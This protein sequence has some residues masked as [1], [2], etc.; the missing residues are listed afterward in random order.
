MKEIG[1]DAFHGCEFKTIYL[2]SCVSEF[3]SNWCSYTKNVEN[4]KIIPNEIKNIISYEDKFIL[5]KS[6]PKSDI[7]DV[8]LF[9]IR[10]LTEVEIPSFIKQIGKSA[11]QECE[12]LTKVTFNDDSELQ[13]IDEF[14]FADSSLESITIPSHVKKIGQNCFRNCF[15]LKKLEFKNDSELQII[16][17][18]AFYGAYIENIVIPKHVKRIPSYAFNNNNY[19]KKLSLPKILNWNQSDN[20]L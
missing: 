20:M 7:Y 19:L 12:K 18:E 6:N 13:I 4:I 3:K 15:K 10:S 16:Q 9:A 8:I 1:R 2:P 11:F 14:S 17:D 5:G